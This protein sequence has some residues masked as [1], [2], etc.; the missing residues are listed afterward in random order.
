MHDRLFVHQTALEADDLV[1]HATALHLD[2]PQFNAALESHAHISRIRDDVLGGIQSGVTGTPT[3]FIN[4]VLH[5]GPSDF[6]ALLNAI[7]R[8]IQGHSPS[9]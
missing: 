6:E 2:I 4:G 5:A 7:E 3:F 9:L 1:L 8:A